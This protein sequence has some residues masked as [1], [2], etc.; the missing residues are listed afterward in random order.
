MARCRSSKYRVNRLRRGSAEL[1][2]RDLTN[3]REI[4]FVVLFTSSL[5]R[6]RWRRPCG[7]CGQARQKAC[8]TYRRTAKSA[9]PSRGT[10]RSRVLQRLLW[11]FRRRRLARLR[12]IPRWRCLAVLANRGGNAIPLQ[13]GSSLRWDRNTTVRSPTRCQRARCSRVTRRERLE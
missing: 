13:P 11:E 10:G 9:G 8:R 12:A 7:P 5:G 3:A 2:R 4:L 6:S 1:T